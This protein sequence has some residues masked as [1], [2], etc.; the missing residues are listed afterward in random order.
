MVRKFTIEYGGDSA[1]DAARIL[2][3]Y[4]GACDP[5][6]VSFLDVDL[7]QNMVV[8]EAH[9]WHGWYRVKLVIDAYYTLGKNGV[10]EVHEV[11]ITNSGHTVPEDSDVNGWG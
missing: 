8:P 3:V 10:H 2:V 1:N 11:R 7:A 4:A 5:F 6:S 9:G